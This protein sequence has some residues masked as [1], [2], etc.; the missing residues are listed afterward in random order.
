ML[1]D[2]SS[3]AAQIPTIKSSRH[4]LKIKLQTELKLNHESGY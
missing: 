2:S 1:C 4:W 3:T